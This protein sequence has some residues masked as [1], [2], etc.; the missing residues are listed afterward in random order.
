MREIQFEG[1]LGLTG[2][3]GTDL[4][5]AKWPK[6]RLSGQITISGLSQLTTNRQCAHRPLIGTCVSI[7]SVS[8]MHADDVK[9]SHKITSAAKA[10]VNSG[11][12]HGQL[13]SDK[14]LVFFFCFL[15][16]FYFGQNL[17]FFVPNRKE[18]WGSRLPE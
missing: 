3:D 14:D 13:R 10:I 12:L 11:D 6:N 2:N 8:R 1:D 9:A 7:G 16:L 4:H 18:K 15:I 5:T 17:S